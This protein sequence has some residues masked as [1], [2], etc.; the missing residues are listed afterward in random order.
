MRAVV[1][2]YTRLSIVRLGMQ[3]APA[4]KLYALYLVD[5]IVKN[6]GR[7]YTALFAGYMPEVGFISTCP[8]CLPRCY[9]DTVSGPVCQPD[10]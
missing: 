3:C 4:H 5:S 7:Q 1:P 8:A 10:A 6:I 9:K 2:Q